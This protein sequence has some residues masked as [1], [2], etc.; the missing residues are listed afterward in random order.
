MNEDFRVGP[1]L[2]APGLNSISCEGTIVRL[3]PKAMEVLVCLARHAGE[4]LSKEILVR[5]VWHDAFVTDDVLTHSIS[6]LRHAFG[7]DAREP[8]FIQT[9]LKRGYRLVAPVSPVPTTSP[10]SVVQDSIVVLPFVNISTDP[11]NEFFA[12][13]ITEEIINALVHIPE[14]HVAARSSAFSFKGKH[15]DPRVV[16]E[17]LNV[18]T[19][20]EGS[21][22]RA[23][24]CLRI[25]AQLVNASDGYHLWSE[26]YDREMKDIF[27]I[28]E[29]IARA[30]ATRLKITLE[31]RPERPLV[32]AGTR[33]LEAYSLYVKGRALLYRRGAE[34]SL[35]L[36]CLNQA[37]SLDSE[38]ALA[39]AGIAD[40][41]T[42]LAF[43]G[44]IHP[45]I[46][47]PK[48]LEAARRA[49]AVD[50]SLAESHTALAFG[51]LMFDC[52][53]SQAER[54]FLQALELNPF[55]IQARDWYACFF[56]QVAMGR[57]AEGITHAISAVET[58]PLSAYANAILGVLCGAAGR[59]SEGLQYAYR[60]LELDG[61]SLLPHW[62][63]QMVFYFS[64]RFRESIAAGEGA[65]RV[66]GRHPWAMAVLATTLRECGKQKEADTIYRELLARADR[67]YVQPTILAFCADAAG[68]PEEAINYALQATAIRDPFRL[69]FSIYWPLG[70]RLRAR[71]HEYP[72]FRELLNQMGFQ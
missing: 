69:G 28:Q 43:Y 13:G 25:T 40:A 52:D 46:G 34:V 31:V 49:V 6:E 15:L 45:E 19:I 66:S 67:E 56:L 35:A 22:R 44:A 64:N 30:I 27:D 17:Q 71:L 41:Y 23:G 18:R 10:T 42:L 47:R 65:L 61:E 2:I 50:F 51:C 70:A 4:T 9:I 20:L 1:W 32:K 11:E 29:D 55:Y 26:R 57:L 36:H 39:W 7:D 63:L 3:E 14:L 58:D 68:Q 33:N 24:D 54:E 37:V 60:A 48:W 21:V 16:G 8:R 53:R 12:D 5:K 62:V 72:R 38:Y 59:Y